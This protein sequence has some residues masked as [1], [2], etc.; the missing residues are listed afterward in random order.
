MDMQHSPG[1]DKSPTER[2]PSP[3][4]AG[5]PFAY[6]VEKKRGK[7]TEK[8]STRYT[9]YRHLKSFLHWCVHAG[10]I[11]RSPLEKVTE[12]NKGKPVPAH[13]TPK[14]LDRLL[15]YIEWHGKN[16]P[17]AC[18]I[19]PDVQWLHDAVVLAVC[20][21]LRCGE[22]L[23]LRWSDVDVDERRIFVRNRR[24]GSFRTKSGSER[25]VP[26]R[27]PARDVLRRRMKERDEG[28]GPV[29]VDRDG[30][31]PKANRLTRRFKDMVREAK[32]RERERLRFHSLRHT[33]GAWLASK[34][35]SE[36]VIQEILGHA[37]SRTTQIYSHVAGL[38]V[39]DA[40][41]RAFGS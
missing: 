39:E 20:T 11:D 30:K 21:G 41:E 31:P 29:I 19:L 34:G 40:M 33:A 38:A 22:L 5:E 12:P 15:D 4:F 9:R 37:T 8:N 2:H 6:Q 28:D 26:V 17:N 10:H 13:L 25:P 3:R 7:G 18:G 32:L 16:K 27:G 24:D 1:A 35:V 14:E 23:N 36:R